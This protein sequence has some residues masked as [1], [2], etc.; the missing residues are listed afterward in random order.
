MNKKLT[1]QISRA[2]LTLLMMLTM[3]LTASATIVTLTTQT[4]EVTLQDGDILTGTGGADTHV[5]IADGATVTLNGVNITAI[6]I[7]DN[8][9]WAGITCLGNAV[10]VL[11]GATTDSVE[12]GS[13][14][15]GIFVPQNKTLTIQGS[16]TLIATGGISGAGI[17]SGHQQSC[18]NIIISHCQPVDQHL[19]AA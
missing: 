12:G 9:Q 4:G 6:A 7:D 1:H 8:H 17:G 3:S 16:G 18:G 2:A 5:S 10:I 19:S 11:E 15:S 13:G 14:S